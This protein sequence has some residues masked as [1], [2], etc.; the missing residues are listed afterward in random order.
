MS[1]NAE[2]SLIF[3]QQSKKKPWKREDKRVNLL[4]RYYIPMVTHII[5]ADLNEK[6]FDITE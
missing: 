4:L 3:I 1:E 2:W 6:L 5:I